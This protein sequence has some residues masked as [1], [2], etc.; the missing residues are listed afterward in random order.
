MRI[1]F[2]VGTFVNRHVT[3]VTCFPASTVHARVTATSRT[4]V[5]CVTGLLRM[6]AIVECCV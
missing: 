1:I 6:S 2:A 5:T 4:S 3:H